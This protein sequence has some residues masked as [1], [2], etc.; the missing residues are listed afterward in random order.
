MIESFAWTVATGGDRP[1]PVLVLAVPV[2][3]PDVYARIGPAVEQTVRDRVR[4]G[5]LN[6]GETYPR[7]DFD[8]YQ[9]GAP[10]ACA[11]A[12]L[13]TAVAIARLTDFSLEYTY[14]GGIAFVA[15]VGLDGALRPVNGVAEAVDTA[16]TL[17]FAIVV[18]AADNGAELAPTDQITVVGART[19]AGVLAWLR[20][21]TTLPTGPAPAMD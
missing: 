7:T 21:T 4:A 19:L 12:D 18:V 8:F 15:E 5:L 9:L 17:G 10:R 20:G 16:A 13:A 3:V 11:A 14:F 1:T 2:T 6:A